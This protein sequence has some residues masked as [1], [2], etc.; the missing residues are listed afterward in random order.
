[1]AQ[2]HD[3]SI[4][5]AHLENSV[6]RVPV[7]PDSR[8][9]L[10]GTSNLRDWTCRA[11]AMDATLEVE[12]EQLD[13]SS[14]LSAKAVRGVSVKVPVRT[15][16]C[17]DRHME[18]N[19]YAA[20]KAP[21]PPAQGYIVA[22]FDR[23]PKAASNLEEIRTTGRMVVAGVERTVEMTV[24]T[25]RLPDGTRRATGSVPILMTDFGI[26]PPRPWM[27]LLRAGN[28]VVIQFEI[29]ISPEALRQAQGV[30]SSAVG[31]H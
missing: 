14:E 13:G 27:G 7:R 20:L 2:T 10:E 24:T 25:D 9:W 18:A 21:N 11:T 29:F 6:V 28:R 26:T 31:D 5:L 17:G 30:S 3:G 23:I 4:A 12:T 16:K 22:E 15:L 19:M 8:L 1:M